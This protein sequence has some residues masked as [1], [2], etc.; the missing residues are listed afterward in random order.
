MLGATLNN[1]R[2]AYGWIGSPLALELF[3]D[4]KWNCRSLDFARDDKG[5]GVAKV[6]LAAGKERLPLLASLNRL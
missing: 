2:A 6:R 3:F 5:K 1:S 4:A